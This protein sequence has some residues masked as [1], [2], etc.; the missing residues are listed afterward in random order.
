MAFF[1]KGVQLG[2]GKREA[3]DTVEIRLKGGKGDQG[4]KGAVAARPKD[5][6]GLGVGRKGT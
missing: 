4:R 2:P 6:G 5:P 1:D 3:V